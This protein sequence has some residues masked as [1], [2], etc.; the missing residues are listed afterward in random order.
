MKKINPKRKKWLVY[1]N[2][3]VFVVGLL[4][5]CV[6]CMSGS[7]KENFASMILLFVGIQSAVIIVSLCLCW[8]L[9]RTWVFKRDGVAEHRT[10]RKDTFIPYS[11]IHAILLCPAVDR[12]FSPICNEAGAQ[13]SVILLFNNS[14]MAR[15]YARNGAFILP[16]TLL[17]DV[18][19]CSFFTPD[20]LAALM[21]KT[22]ATIFVRKETCEL[23]KK[24]LNALLD[25]E[26]E[27]IIVSV[28]NDIAQPQFVS[29]NDF[30]T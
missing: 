17:D 8:P 14:R 11:E 29:F 3:A 30:K 9:D 28:S 22:E 13:E 21:E 10:M 27:R 5:C 24:Q 15:N 16:S 6:L 25:T 19:S 20:K 23:F 7:S 1:F 4:V 2:A 18:L 26:K 12:Y